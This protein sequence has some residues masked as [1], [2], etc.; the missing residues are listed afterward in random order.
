MKRNFDKTRLCHRHEYLGDF[1][2]N[3]RK[4]KRIKI[5]EPIFYKRQAG[6]KEFKGEVNNMSS[7]G[8]CFESK[9]PYL[10]GT[11]LYM[12][13]EGHMPNKLDKTNVTWSKPVH[14]ISHR[15]PKYK[16]GVQFVTH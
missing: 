2:M 4:A 3:E 8:I 6:G 10:P 15:H 11:T 1:V 13:T 7:K 14:G 16:V 12:E 9:V 5:D